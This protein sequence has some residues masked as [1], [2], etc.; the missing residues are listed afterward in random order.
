MAGQVNIGGTTASVQLVGNDSYTTDR[1]FTFPDADGELLIAD[2]SGDVVITGDLEVGGDV[3]MASLN[4]AGLNNNF[5]INGAMEVFQ[6]DTGSAFVLAATSGE[7]VADRW[8]IRSNV[9]GADTTVT[10]P[11]IATENHPQGCFKA[12]RLAN[13]TSTVS[14]PAA[15]Y[16]GIQQILEQ[17]TTRAQS[18]SLVFKMTFYTIEFV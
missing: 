14:P 15:Q 5:L 4:G 9:I 2:S 18:Q 8:K 16:V 3:Q 11:D 10:V 6:R 13:A 17:S 1:Q 7:Y 12:I